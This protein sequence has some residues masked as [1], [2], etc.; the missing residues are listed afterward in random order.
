MNYFLFFILS[1]KTL[2]GD[3]IR[4]TYNQSDKETIT[5]SFYYSAPSQ[6]LLHI[7]TP[8]NQI[9]TWNKDT[10]IIFYPEEKKAFKISKTLNP[11]PQLIS[12]ISGAQGIENLGW[13]LFKKVKKG[14]TLYSYFV[15][16]KQEIIGSMAIGKIKNKIVASEIRDTDGTL[17]AKTSFSRHLQNNIPSRISLWRVSDADTTR[18]EIELKNMIF[19]SQIPDTILHFSIPQSPDIEITYW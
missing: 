17:I 11:L 19:N 8:T 3:F 5:G 2:T 12:V 4:E 16:E 1:L 6:I 7:K 18:E 9:L 15:S 14:D 13:T 10:L